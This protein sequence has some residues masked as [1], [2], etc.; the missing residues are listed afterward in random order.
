MS[1]PKAGWWSYVKHMIRHYPDRVNQEEYA[2][3]KAALEE[4]GRRENGAN[5]LKVVQMVL[6]RG[7]H[8]LAGAALLIPC[9]ERTAQRW[10]AD[11]IRAV[12]R[13][14]RCDGLK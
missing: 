12:G 11:F 9:C 8:T 14:F 13:N 5:R 3:V 7:T 10:H 6:I 1:R 2:A 4:T